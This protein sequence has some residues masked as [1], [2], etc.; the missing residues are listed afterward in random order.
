MTTY[1][2][3]PD[4]HGQAELL[5]SLLRRLGYSDRRGAWR[6]PDRDRSAIFLGDFIDRGPDQAATIDIVRRMT[7]EGTAQAVMGNHEL[8]ALLYHATDPATGRPLRAHGRTQTAQHARFLSEFPLGMAR[9][10]D[11]LSWMARLPLWLET[12]EFRAVHA[13]WHAA[14]IALIRREIFR[15][16]L[17]EETLLAIARK[18]DPLREAVETLLKGPEIR[19]PP[20]VQL[21]DNAGHTRS[22][23]RVAWWTRRM[24]RWHEVVASWPDDQPLPPGPVKEEIRERLLAVTYPSD[25]IPVFFG[26]YWLIGTPRLQADNILCLDYSAGKG[27]PLV[28]YRLD[29]DSGPVTPL[30]LERLTICDPPG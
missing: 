17:D 20:G 15:D 4:I 26:H 13:C 29:R 22:D 28:S 1:D 30:A 9:T 18:G 5:T 25:A 10:R 19:L 21:V 23:S 12:P 24:T 3:I 11:V 14:S 2:I 8:N 16:C 7:G 6:H 27:G